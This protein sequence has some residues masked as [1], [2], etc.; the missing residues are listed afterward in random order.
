MFHM[1]Q[2]PPGE[3]VTVGDQRIHVVR[4]DRSS[5]NGPVVVLCGGLGSNW[6]DWDDCAHILSASHTVVVF[7]R[8]GFGLSE[9]LAEG[10]TPTVR[11]EADRILGVLDALGLTGPAV[12]VG[13]SIAGFYVEAFARLHP[14]RTAGLLLLDSSVEREPWWSIPRPLIPRPLIPRRWRLGL[15]PRLADGLSRSGMQRLF[16]PTVRRVLNH[17]IPPDG[18]PIETVDWVDRIYRRPSY[19]AAALVENVVYAD[20]AAELNALRCD[21]PMVGRGGVAPVT[22][23]AAHTG[24]PTPWGHAWLAKQLRLAEYLGAHFTVISPAHHHAMIDQPAQVA[25]LISELVS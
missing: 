15:A 12:V 1:K 10:Q 3:M 5:Q 21:M 8:P 19:L 14:E 11:A 16:G 22:V 13:H 9:P 6:F 23:A 20:M 18:V 25:A 17:S 2:R 24:H 7:D 4:R